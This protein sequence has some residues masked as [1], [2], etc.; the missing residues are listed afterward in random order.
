VKNL[1]FV[2]MASMAVPVAAQVSEEA[3]RRFVEG[4]LPHAP[5]STTTVRIERS[6]NTGSGPY[7]VATAVQR[8]AAGRQQQ[9]GLLVDPG[10]RT[11]TAGMVYPL[12]ESNP[13]VTP[14]TLQQFVESSVPQMLSSALR[15][16]VRVRWPVVPT[17]Q[18]G[19][20][21]LTA[22][23]STGYGE[24]SMPIAVTADGRTL[25]LGNN[26]PLNRDPRAVRRELI[27]EAELQT[28]AK[29]KE[30]AL[31]VAEFSD[32]QCPACAAGWPHLRDA[33]AQFGD[34]V[35]YGMGN[36][37]LIQSSPWS[38]RAAVAGICVEQLD[39]GSYI[40]FKEEV[41]RIRGSMTLQTAD[42]LFR[43]FVVQRDL[44]VA[45]FD[46]C[47][48]KEPAINRVL[49]HM[50]LGHR[51]GVQGTPTYYAG[52]E[53]LPFGDW[54]TIRSRLTAIVAAGGIPESAE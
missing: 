35:Q 14:A 27:Q 41:Y 54:D 46:A 25:A 39:P 13:P 5:G 33:M 45:K 43:E 51:M 53:Q 40:D 23:V 32:F 2:M 50:E 18:T 8:L 42:E 12:P 6:V 7:L 47:Y 34:R 37:P 9:V 52:G 36:F 31:L 3:L 10:T 17:R 22:A 49:R 1:L 21:A 20:T 16:R 15:S 48:M 4:Y 19:V 38:F 44:D 29:V 28:G 30:G 24:V 11:V 26:W